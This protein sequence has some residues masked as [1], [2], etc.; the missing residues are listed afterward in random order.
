M[1]IKLLIYGEDKYNLELYYDLIRKILA[2]FLKT[3]ISFIYIKKWKYIN[4]SDARDI[5]VFISYN[6]DIDFEKLK[7]YVANR[8]NIPKESVEVFLKNG[9]TEITNETLIALGFPKLLNDSLYGVRGTSQSFD[10][11]IRTRFNEALYRLVSFY[12]D[13]SGDKSYS[14][15]EDDY[16]TYLVKDGEY[17]FVFELH[18][19]YKRQNTKP[20]KELIRK[21]LFYTNNSILKLRE[22]M[23][24][25]K[26]D[27]IK[28]EKV[29][30]LKKIDMKREI[31]KKILGENYEFE[32]LYK[33]PMIFSDSIA[34]NL[35]MSYYVKVE[36]WKLPLSK[37][38]YND[39]Y[40]IIDE[41]LKDNFVIYTPSGV[42]YIAKVDEES[43][44]KLKKF[45][46]RRSIEK[47][48]MGYEF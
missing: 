8:L 25:Y 33:Y 40:L 14:I 45:L 5:E 42:A 46:L 30:N 7:E 3:D 43:L 21:C 24:K 9:T 16:K 35:E 48:E 37:T 36:N 10:L 11:S 1:R 34:K 19:A 29:V 32:V 15:V 28:S 17:I 39:I 22:E 41:N 38:K 27:G 4:D 20:I 23:E 2:D 6:I 12:A 44:G 18:N 26:I 47:G 13:K 31:L